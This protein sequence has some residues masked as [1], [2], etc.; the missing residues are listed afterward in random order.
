MINHSQFLVK[1]LILSN[2]FMNQFDEWRSIFLVV[3]NDK[4]QPIE[5]YLKQCTEF[6]NQIVENN[7]L[8][9]PN[10]EATES[11]LKDTLKQAIRQLLNFN[12]NISTKNKADPIMTFLKSC[13]P[14]FSWAYLNDRF[15][16]FPILNDIMNPNQ[17][18]YKTIKSSFLI[19][20][21]NKNKRGNNR[22]VYVPTKF[23]TSNPI[24]T[25]YDYFL[26]HEL[27][28][29]MTIRFHNYEIPAQ[30]EHLNF[31]LFHF[32][33][34]SDKITE[35][36]YTSLLYTFFNFFDNYMK[37]NIMPTNVKSI[38]QREILS[39]FS[40]IIE[41]SNKYSFEVPDSTLQLIFNYGNDQIQNKNL[42]S[43]LFGTS[44]FKLF[45]ESTE[46]PLNFFKESIEKTN[47]VTDFMSRDLHPDVISNTIPILTKMSSIKC[48]KLDD[49]KQICQVTKNVHNTQKEKMVNLMVN[50]LLE[51]PFEEASNFFNSNMD[52]SLDYLQFVASYLTKK[53]D[54]P[55]D[56]A[57]DI[58]MKIITTGSAIYNRSKEEGN[59]A[60]KNLIR[61]IYNTKYKKSFLNFCISQIMS[62][63]SSFIV[64][65][66]GSVACNCSA[67]IRSDFNIDVFDKLCSYL[68]VIDVSERKIVYPLVYLLSKPLQKKIS[69]TLLKA[70]MNADDSSIWSF[71]TFLMTQSG[72]NSFEKEAVAFIADTIQGMKK[73]PECK[74]FA[75]FF[76]IFMLL[77]NIAD[78]KITVENARNQN[79]IPAKYLV[80]NLPL[81]FEDKLLEQI[82]TFENKDVSS[83]SC[84]TLLNIYS[85][86]EYKS[87][88]C[89]TFVHLLE[90]AENEEQ[91]TRVVNLVYDYCLKNDNERVS[92]IITHSFND[93]SYFADLKS[94]INL[95]VK[96][97]LN[98]QEPPNKDI[99]PI[100][101]NKDTPVQIILTLVSPN[102]PD[103][104]SKYVVMTNG[105]ERSNCQVNY[106][107]GFVNNKI[108]DIK[109]R[110]GTDKR[111]LT[112]GSPSEYLRILRFSEKLIGYLKDTEKVGKNDKLLNTI[113][114]LL[115]Y[116]PSD[117]SLQELSSKPDLFIQELQQATN[118]YY[119]RYL[120]QI[121]LW[122]LRSPRFENLYSSVIQPVL[123]DI[124]NQDR[125]AAFC[126]DEI[127]R[128]LEKYPLPEFIVPA[129]K[130]LAN[131][132]I[133]EPTKLIASS[134][135]SRFTFD[136]T[137]IVENKSN[138]ELIMNSIS[139][140]SQKV[141][142]EFKN[143]LFKIKNEKVLYSMSINALTKNLSNSPFF[144]EIF[145]LYLPN[146]L[147]EDSNP[148]ISLCLKLMKDSPSI[149]L[150]NALND[151]ITH[152]V[153]SKSKTKNSDN[154]S[155]IVDKITSVIECCNDSEILSKLFNSISKINS[156]DSSARPSIDN[157]I[158]KVN[159]IHLDRWSFTPEIH[160]EKYR[161]L[162]NLQ[163]TCYMNSDLQQLY[164]IPAFRYLLSREDT[165]GLQDDKRDF[166][167]SLQFLMDDM[168]LMK[169]RYCDTEVFFYSFSKL[170]GGMFETNEQQDAQEFLTF[171]LDDLPKSTKSLFEGVIV[172]TIKEKDT[173][174]DDSNN[175]G[176]V[177]LLEEQFLTLPLPIKDVDDMNESLRSF[178]QTQVLF[179]DNQYRL[180]DGS[181][182]DA[183]K[184]QRIKVAPPVLIIQLKRFE[185]DMTTFDRIK[186][187]KQFEILKNI[188]LKE[189]M[190]NEVKNDSDYNYTL[191]GV[192]VHRGEGSH[193][194]YTSLIDID[195]DWYRFDDID[196]QKVDEKTYRQEA[197]GPSEEDLKK[198]NNKNDDF[199][200]YMM[201]NISGYLLFYINDDYKIDDKLLLD[202]NFDIFIPNDKK[203]SIE[204]QNRS[205]LFDQLAFLEPTFYF[206]NEISK[207]QQLRD[208]F[209]N[210]FSHSKQNSQ[211]LS[212]LIVE[213]I[214]E[215]YQNDTLLVVELINWMSDN[216]KEKVLEIYL[217]C[218]ALDIV[219]A[220]SEIILFSCSK[221]QASESGEFI[222]N[223]ILELQA[224]IPKWRQIS[225]ISKMIIKYLQS[226]PKNIEFA[227]NNGWSDLIMMFIYEVFN[228]SRNDN[229]LKIIN[230]TEI[231]EIAKLIVSYESRHN[232][233]DLVNIRDFVSKSPSSY[234]AY[235]SL[236]V[237]CT[238]IDIF[239]IS[240]MSKLIPEEFS[241]PKIMEMY[242]NKVEPSNFNEI[243]IKTLEGEMKFNRYLVMQYFISKK[244]E[245]KYILVGN[246][247]YLIESLLM[248]ETIYSDLCTKT[249]NLMIDI[250]ED[251][252]ISMD[253]KK[254]AL[255]RMIAII[256]SIKTRFKGLTK[257][258]PFLHVLLILMK[259][260]NYPRNQPINGLDELK[261]DSE[262]ML[263]ISAYS[264]SSHLINI[265]ETR[266]NKLINNGIP[267]STSLVSANKFISEFSAVLE[268]S[269]DDLF[270]QIIN[271]NEWNLII[272]KFK[273]SISAYDL[274]NLQ[275]LV[276]I[277]IKRISSLSS[278]KSVN[279][280]IYFIIKI[281]TQNGN[282]DPHY[283]SHFAKYLP[284]FI[285]DVKE[286][287]IIEI[288]LRVV[289]NVFYSSNLQSKF[290]DTLIQ[291]YFVSIPT[292]MYKHTNTGRIS[293][294]NFPKPAGIPSD[295]N[296]SEKVSDEEAKE[297]NEFFATLSISQVD[298]I[299]IFLTDQKREN[300][301]IAMNLLVCLASFNMIYLEDLVR[302]GQNKLESLSISVKGSAGR[303]ID[304][305]IVASLI[306][307]LKILRLFKSMTGK[308]NSDE[309][310]NNI[311][312]EINGIIEN[313]TNASR[314]YQQQGKRETL[315]FI[316]NKIQ[317]E[318][319]YRLSTSIAKKIFTNSKF[320][321]EEE[322]TFF[323]TALK[324]LKDDEIKHL[325][326]EC[327][328][329]FNLIGSVQSSYSTDAAAQLEKIGL[330]VELFSDKLMKEEIISYF[331]IDKNWKGQSNRHEKAIIAIYGE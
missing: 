126:A 285:D 222:A 315:F 148:Q 76:K 279:D 304:N 134:I 71:L 143:F 98:S 254:D 75:E 259:I 32:N 312:T 164:H 205:Y 8:I 319:Y 11:F 198:N 86:L 61:P 112:L 38:D 139:I 18:L 243:V 93:K 151:I 33:K 225:E 260:T 19:Q 318:S 329:E 331:T 308:E 208:Y 49:L 39:I 122:R 330:L 102:L 120:Y 228:G 313:Y 263:A 54:I 124:V 25:L 100:A 31:F 283:C 269:S 180:P 300:A 60:I 40:I 82:L 255:N 206:F 158:N 154:E 268:T 5:E 239:E 210:I 15:D 132:D 170:H 296:A 99:L 232:Y 108:I 231:F 3:L 291:T 146:F 188:S 162:R 42:H 316:L 309:L 246:P 182:I 297:F 289:T 72:L 242:L 306:I 144:T 294:I 274:Q 130:I 250:Y 121:L 295:Q 211:E 191:H 81:D 192:V 266:A 234:G 107:N 67:T 256:P 68:T 215:L 138:V 36:V 179:G 45:T 323:R 183:E 214:K 85:K 193:G 253:I 129:L 127:V 58:I 12:I 94:P 53:K 23:D 78:T 168:A 230:I 34:M 209:F 202:N 303:T 176:F 196:V 30:V 186:I 20:P 128:L 136:T 90:M 91:R 115:C 131:K 248:T 156:Y 174:N 278:S 96:F 69:G 249:E 161:G 237:K 195:N 83:I 116:L 27:F 226:S 229:A 298:K 326:E 282:C 171:F 142:N 14:L 77:Y 41:L 166:I 275:H 118:K 325:L 159:G 155:K 212:L 51:L 46:R 140:M 257:T 221:V 273:S 272:S 238:S 2:P 276:E 328:K 16:L 207:P 106:N 240:K 265:F 172:N 305:Y 50:L 236:I 109:N 165:E 62:E 218:S 194:H 92:N 150:A 64:V 311:A 175:S 267:G 152:K 113:W 270:T 204:L 227:Q 258:S 74:E 123:I 114:R 203:S 157:F 324:K 28:T 105:V 247:D 37:V 181:S 66:L 167:K 145:S 57:Q 200:F 133:K 70:I 261:S 44:I 320:E 213:R 141:W 187:N 197:F 219:H 307:Q 29:V 1:I 292:F 35:N 224:L 299:Y 6:I 103:G 137:K 13:L 4:D 73:M 125:L 135:I 87:S 287:K 284:A 160:V 277:I 264:D 104:Q 251:K 52:E 22:Y 59:S 217:H 9:P 149:G 288:L 153:Q 163:A 147:A 10:M 223:F 244:N 56:M 322:K 55:N 63:Y 169:T 48:I 310:K 201:S 293:N 302:F 95:K 177:Q 235:K 80:K 286:P 317:N 178:L 47:F 119:I 117:E 321:K 245:F 252:E 65:L 24:F 190:T 216:F 233:T 199:E 84:Q 262:Y 88:L 281:I 79:V 184:S 301:I 26:S 327:K 111:T 185:Y 101:I 7:F 280:S 314:G 97:E 290:R 43:Q 110:I 89:D 17:N 21:S 173:N 220:L 271:H 241:K 189:L